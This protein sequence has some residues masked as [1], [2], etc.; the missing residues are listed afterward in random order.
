[1]YKNIVCKVLMYRSSDKFKIIYYSLSLSS[2]V[3][4]P[5]CSWKWPLAWKMMKWLKRQVVLNKGQKKI[6]SASR[7]HSQLVCTMFKTVCEPKFRNKIHFFFFKFPPG[8]MILEAS[9]ARCIMNLMQSQA[10]II[11]STSKKMG[12]NILFPYISKALHIRRKMISFQPKRKK[13]LLRVPM[14]TNLVFK[15]YIKYSCFLL[16]LLPCE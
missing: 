10:K 2:L 12:K 8:Y 16:E 7:G 11:W 6:R 9:S 15:H 4:R 13:R 14:A 1:M 5:K 3:N